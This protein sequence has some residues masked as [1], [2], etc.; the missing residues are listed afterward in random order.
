MPEPTRP[1]TIRPVSTGPSS[2]T[3]DALTSRPTI[4]RAPN[5]SSVIP[6]LQRQHH[7]GEHSGQQDDGERSQTD[8]VELLDDIAEVE[9]PRHQAAADLSEH[10]HVLLHFEQ[11]RL[12]PVLQRDRHDQ[13]RLPARPSSR[14]RSCLIRSRS[15]AAFSNSRFAAA[16]FICICSVAICA[17]SSPCVRKPSM[18]VGTVT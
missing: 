12:E 15:C 18:S 7:A 5:T 13:V 9:R 3:I 14:D 16:P 10:V 4:D 2:F 11:R 17:S 1:A 6:D 8:R